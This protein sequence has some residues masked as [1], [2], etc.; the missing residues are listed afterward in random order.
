MTK[1][2]LLAFACA[3]V[4]PCGK[5]V[6][7]KAT[8]GVVSKTGIKDIDDLLGPS[9]GYA[10]MQEPQMAF[11][12][13]FCG[14][15]FLESDKLRKCVARGT[16]VLMKDG[17]I[18]AI[19]D[20]RVGDMVA[21]YKDGVCSS[22]EVIS[23]SNNGTKEVVNIKCDSGFSIKCT[24]DHMILTQ[25]GYVEAKDLASDDFVFTPKSIARYSD[26][27]RSNQKMNS[28]VLWM[29][30]ALIGDGTIFSMEH[31]AF[32]N[33]DIEIIDKFKTSVMSLSDTE[34]CDLK[35]SSIDGKTVDKIYTVKPHGNIKRIMW[36]LIVR[37]G[38]NHH[39]QGKIIPYE[40]QKYSPTEKLA[41][42]IAGMFNTDGGYSIFRKAIE[43]YTISERLI[44]QLQS[45][46]LKFGIYSIIS[47]KNVSKYNYLAYELNICD[48]DSLCNFY[49]YI[50][51]YIVGR[52]YEDFKL[53]INSN[54]TKRYILPE[55]CKNEFVNYC[56]SRNISMRSLS[57]D[58]FGKEY[59]MTNGY[60]M[61]YDIGT[62]ISEK[63][64]MPLTY[65]ILRSDF[66]TQ[67]VMSIQ[68]YGLEEVY[69]IGVKETHNFIANGIVV[70]NCVAKKL[71]TREQLP[72]I[73]KMWEEN[74]KIRYNLTD[75]QSEAIIEPFLQCILDATRYSFSLVHSLSYS[76]ISYECGW[77]RYHYPLE[78]ITSCLN[79]W[80]GNDEKTAEAIEYATKKGIRILLP[81]FRHSK[82]DY[83]FDKET[84]SI[85]RGTSSVKGISASYA[86]ALYE[87][88][89]REYNS[90]IE[91]LYDIQTIG[92]PKDQI[93][94]LIK[95]DYF[96]EFGTIKELSL[97]YYQFQC[98]KKG[99][100]KTI[101]KDKLTDKIIYDIVARN[102][103]ETAK[104]FNKIN[105]RNILIEIEQYIK[106]LSLGDADIKTKI[107]N[108]MDYMGYI[109]IK[110]DKLEDRPRIIVLS[111][112]VLKSAKTNKPW[113]ISMDGQSIGSAKRANYTIR[114]SLYEKEQFNKCDIIRIKDWERDK[115]GYYWITN[116]VKEIC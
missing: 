45:Q 80:N 108:Q 64:Y 7:E 3:L 115:R 70:H 99:E 101:S 78:Y 85:Y 102:A 90:F 2:D 15:T 100:A 20:I 51:P 112:R 1:L 76:C 56:K 114:Y 66:I 22:S 109:G 27:I 95:L 37:Y 103:N 107:Q 26:G 88:R 83:F 43:Y 38:I 30:G 97:I 61:T 47:K 53:I 71:G 52:K 73:K 6:Y 111:I 94:A 92:V 116:F 57:L 40:I 5:G 35:V 24:K 32:T 54:N 65:Q 98:F 39:A 84:N 14:Y 89:D 75:E 21:T 33:S 25:R 68:D 42:F 50:M 16:R 36:N 104:Q 4:R 10:I 46:L 48:I 29:M 12:Q 17:S 86:E 110:T 81:K 55:C 74:A 79:T 41:S 60:P 69:D 9:M 13:K 8:S 113:A 105:C 72:K 96:E 106:S 28:D 19:E 67:K 31:L 58:K 49:K 44:Y 59:R 87:L 34:N 18:K 91:L 62:I 23:T 77:L 63:I 82:A 11:V 93:E